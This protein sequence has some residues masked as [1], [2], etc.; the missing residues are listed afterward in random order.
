M[1]KYSQKYNNDR[2]QI[3]ILI[4]KYNYLWE[5]YN[6][7]LENLIYGQYETVFKTLPFLLD[8]IIGPENLFLNSSKRVKKIFLKKWEEKYEKKESNPF[9]LLKEDCLEILHKVTSRKEYLKMKKI[10]K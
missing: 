8:D 7:I 5:R 9:N 6:Q 3:H 4:T 2:K 1:P 10:I